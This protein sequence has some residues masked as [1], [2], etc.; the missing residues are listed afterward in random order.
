MRLAWAI[1]TTMLVV[2]GSTMHA[3]QASSGA[4]NE[5]YP[6]DGPSVKRTDVPHPP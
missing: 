5:E 2:D 4:M 6:T 3:M 1:G